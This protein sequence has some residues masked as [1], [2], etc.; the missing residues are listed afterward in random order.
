V[1]RT[2]VTVLSVLAVTT[3]CGSPSATVPAEDT[4]PRSSSSAPA[5]DTPA[6]A[7]GGIPE[8]APVDEWTQATDSATGVTF[9]L[10]R[11]AT[12]QTRPGVDGVSAE[13][14]LY[15]A[16]VSEKL[17]MSVSFTSA[18]GAEYSP[19]GLQ[20]IVDQLVAQ[21]ETAGAEDVEAFDRTPTTIGGRPALDF[22][23]SFTSREGER[24]IWFVRYVGNG[25]TAIQ[26]QSIAFVD[27]ADETAATAVVERYH[28]QLLG[29][30]TM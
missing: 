19:A 24:S 30:L 28:Q 10:P 8:P 7:A 25:S 29:T 16:E 4:P 27:P 13:T 17:N 6:P 21:F 9:A 15:G 14:V 20:D 18:P 22:R 11:A 1:R 5:E 26:L 12:R 3:A 2:V 23:L